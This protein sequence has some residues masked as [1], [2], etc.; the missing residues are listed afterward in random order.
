MLCEKAGFSSCY[1]VSTQTYSRK[2]DLQ[3]ANALA[4]LGATAQQMCSDI[5]HLASWKEIE[6]PFE[7]SQIGSRQVI[8]TI[9]SFL[10]DITVRWHTNEIQ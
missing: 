10:T 1:S 3:V 9:S 2:V 4:G 8:D 6:E 7:K 5:R